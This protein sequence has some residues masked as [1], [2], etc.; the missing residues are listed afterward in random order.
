[1]I[2]HLNTHGYIHIHRNTHTHTHTMQGTTFTFK[3]IVALFLFVLNG[4]TLWCVITQSEEQA[5]HSS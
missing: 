1:M 5:L 3:S 4:L 2:I